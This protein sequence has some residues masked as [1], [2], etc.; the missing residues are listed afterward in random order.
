[1]ENFESK[2]E[3]LPLKEGDYFIRKEGRGDLK[4]IVIKCVRI[5]D[6]GNPVLSCDDG[7]EFVFEGKLYSSGWEILDPV[8]LENLFIQIELRR[9]IR[10]IKIG[11]NQESPQ[12]KQV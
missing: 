3:L 11:S 4:G 6:K 1:M 9:K 7:K 12:P 8:K 5:N 10:L 2:D